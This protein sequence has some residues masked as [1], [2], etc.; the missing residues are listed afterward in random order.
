MRIAMQQQLCNFAVKM[1]TRP[2]AARNTEES[3]GA[4]SPS[5]PC[6]GTRLVPAVVWRQDNSEARLGV[7][8]ESCPR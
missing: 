3:D 8:E 5:Q 7:P 4:I 2:Q 1:L 6:R